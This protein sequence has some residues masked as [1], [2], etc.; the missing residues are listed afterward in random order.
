MT[1]RIVV[2]VPKVVR[3]VTDVDPRDTW[4][5]QSLAKDS[6]LRQGWHGVYYTFKDEKDAILFMLRWGG[7]RQ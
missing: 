4:C 5:N 7:E 3:Y 2:G 1:N 6:W